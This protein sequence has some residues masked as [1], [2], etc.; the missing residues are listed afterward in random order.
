MAN[1]ENG[2]VAIT[3]GGKDYIM[4][5]GTFALAEL[6]DK[7][8]RPF[9]EVLEELNDEKSFRVKT[10]VA[11]IWAALQHH[12]EGLSMREAAEIMDSIGIK[13]AADTISRALVLAF[14]EL[15]VAD[16]SDVNPTGNRRQR[17]AAATKGKRKQKAAD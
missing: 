7:L 9:A 12:H 14:P 17:R 6:E 16:D 3:A 2:E 4:K 8:G 10:A 5:F 1:K 15:E 11:T 13:E